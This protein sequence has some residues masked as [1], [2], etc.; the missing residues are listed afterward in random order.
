LLFSLDLGLSN[1][2]IRDI[3]ETTS[4]DLGRKGKDRYFGWGRINIYNALLA[5][6][7][8]SSNVPPVADF[9]YSTNGLTV[10]F[11]DESTDSDGEI[12]N[13][14]WDF[15]D[16]GTS[17]SQ[18]PPYTFAAAGT[19]EITLTVTDDNQ[20]TDSIIK[21]IT[22]TE[23]G[24]SGE[25]MHVS[26]IAMSHVKHGPNY[27]VDTT[28]VIVSESGSAVSDATVTIE[29]TLPD[30]KTTFISGITEIDGTV[31]LTVKAK[32]K[33]EYISTVKDVTHA[34]LTYAPEANIENSESYFVP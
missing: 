4:D 10:N 27:F 7:G 26:D 24:A 14:F 8:S 12:T 11:T 18:N 3:I 33:G 5:A 25:G 17:T 9:S 30:G 34:V 16:G 20:G 31:T 29:S 19:Y 6:Y 21:F 28:V 1:A 13:W 22:V 15:G 2:D 23:G 32:Q